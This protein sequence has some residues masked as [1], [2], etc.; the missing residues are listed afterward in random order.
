[1]GSLFDSG[2]RFLRETMLGATRTGFD[3]PW[4]RAGPRDG[5]FRS[6]APLGECSPSGDCAEEVQ[7]ELVALQI[8]T[9]REYLSGTGREIKSH[10]KSLV[11]PVA[12]EQDP[13]LIRTPREH[14]RM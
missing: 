8:V 4:T 12:L 6:M 11:S 5:P 9:A 1:M 7:S 14:V 3:M 13:M 2:N 10:E